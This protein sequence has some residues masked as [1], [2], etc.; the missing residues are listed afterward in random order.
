MKDIIKFSIKKKTVIKLLV[1]LTMY[2]F[3]SLIVSA[4]II[5]FRTGSFS[6][7]TGVCTYKSN[8]T[9]YDP[10]VNI[11]CWLFKEKK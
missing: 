8:Y 1:G 11:F 5:E 6:P 10:S 7:K 3:I 9:K 4:T 2:S